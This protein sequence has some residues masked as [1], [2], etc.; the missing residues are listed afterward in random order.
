MNLQHMI[1]ASPGLCTTPVL[2]HNPVQITVPQNPFS[3]NE[4]NF[5]EVKDIKMGVWRSQQQRTLDSLRFQTTEPNFAPGLKE[6][7]NDTHGFRGG[8]GE[9][10]PLGHG[11]SLRSKE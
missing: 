9:D 2:A 3:A 6:K 4:L 1:R 7:S 10:S 5:D 8:G 11:E